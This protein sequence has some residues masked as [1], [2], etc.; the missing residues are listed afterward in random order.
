[1]EDVGIM[2][3]ESTNVEQFDSQTDGVEEVH[4]ADVGQEQQV[5][6]DPWERLKNAGYDPYKLEKTFNTFTKKLEE[7]RA[8]IRKELD[9]VMVWKQL[10][11]EIMSNPEL[12]EY[13]AAFFNREVTP[14]DELYRVRSEV[15]SLRQQMTVKEELEQLREYISENG[16]PEIDE[17]E[18]LQYAAENNSPDLIT[19]YKAKTYED[20]IKLAEERAFNKVRKSK[21]A[22][23]PKVENSKTV[24]SESELNDSIIAN[25]SDEEFQRR[26]NE[27]LDYY[28]SRG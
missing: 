25:M 16:L 5:D 10:G 23:I 1:M 28:R 22:A 13:I 17:R 4:E 6:E 19:A 12:Q 21:G 20:A 18:L 27:I 11:E 14:L 15:E 26:Y 7:E 3:Q 24:G 8:K 9:D 2:E